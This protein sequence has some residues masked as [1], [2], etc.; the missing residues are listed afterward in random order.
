MARNRRVPGPRLAAGVTRHRACGFRRCVECGRV[1]WPLGLRFR[2]IEP[3]V[4]GEEYDALDRC[5]ACAF[6]AGLVEG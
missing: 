3:R 4:Y 2:V 6:W 1:L 5:P